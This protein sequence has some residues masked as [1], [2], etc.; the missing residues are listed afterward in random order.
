[1]EIKI[2]SCLEGARKAEGLT[3][4]IDVFR[5]SNTI[6]TCLGQGANYVIPVGEL[7]RA[8]QLKKDHPQYLLAGERNS[9]A[10]KGFDFSNSPSYVSTLNLSQQS[11]ILTT[12]AGTQG[13][14]HAIDAD[15]I[16]IG[17]FANAAA[18]VDYI[19]KKQPDTVTLAPMG[20]ASSEKAEEDEQ[21]AFYLKERLL[22]R[23]PDLEEIRN[24]IRQSKGADRLKRIGRQDDL[25]FG[26]KL[27]L[28]SMVPLYNRAEGYLTKN[29]KSQI[30]N[31][32]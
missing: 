31:N 13:I 30:P 8:Y 2:K 27:D 1:M 17:S 22:G 20:F 9:Q 12:S 23:Q 10:P 25:E 5:S 21:C 3:V 4:I 32:K 6:I 18:V 29:S 19:N 26:L 11:V 28:Y 14:V 24:K 16:V 15:E 7:E